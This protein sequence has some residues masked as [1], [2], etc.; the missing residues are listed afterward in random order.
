VST[1]L[2]IVAALIASVGSCASPFGASAL[3]QFLVGVDAAPAKWTDVGPSPDGEQG[4]KP[5]GI[6]HAAGRLLINNH[7]DDTRSELYVVSPT[8]G[9]I[10]RR[11][12][13]P[14]DAVH[15]A[16]LGWDGETLWA[17]DYSNGDL[18]G[19]DLQATLTSSKSVVRHRHRT[20]LAG[21]SGLVVFEWES[22]W[23]FAITE[24]GGT[25]RGWVI[26]RS[27]L[28]QMDEDGL[29][30]AAAFSWWAGGFSQG[31]TFDGRY[32]YDA[33]NVRGRDVV[34]VIDAA[35]ALRGERDVAEVVGFVEGPA[36]LI[37]DLT[38]VDGTMWT[39]DEGSFRIYRLDDYRSVLPAR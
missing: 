34:A 2:A 19:L 24:F 12:Q 6:V 5:Q 17:V 11:V 4:Y 13:L 38:I 39:S 27:R 29:A 36:E 3:W 9:T 20:G 18:Y 37:E 35:A 16:G 8:D 22:Q 23:W 33:Q 31:A 32:F 30:S 10:R 28:E 15:L 7:W 21:A 1:R 25:E 26:P 14:E